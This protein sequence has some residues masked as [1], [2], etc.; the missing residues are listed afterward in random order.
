MRRVRRKGKALV[1]VLFTPKQTKVKDPNEIGKHT[2]RAPTFTLV[3][4][5]FSDNSRLKTSFLSQT[6]IVKDHSNDLESNTSSEACFEAGSKAEL[7]E[8]TDL[9]LR[10]LATEVDQDWM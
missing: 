10:V 8:K 2:S 5:Q 7:D 1:L 4:A 3:Y 6:L 9:F